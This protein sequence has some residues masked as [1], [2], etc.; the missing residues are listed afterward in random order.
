MN[1]GFF[2]TPYDG[3][4]LVVRKKVFDDHPAPSGNSMIAYVLLRLSRIYGDD[5]LEAKA[6]SVLKLELGGLQNGPSSFGWGLVAADLYLAKPREVAIV[7]PLDAPVVR[8]ALTRW[9]PHAVIVYGPAE[10]IPLLDG[11]ELVDGKAAVYVCERFT[12]QAPVT[13]PRELLKV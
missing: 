10:D 1:G 9:D 7:G 6:V 11:K 3:E 13:D 5:D 4:A 2:E 8:R 12:C